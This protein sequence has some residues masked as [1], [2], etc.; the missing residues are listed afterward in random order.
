[1][2]HGQRRHAF[3]RDTANIHDAPADKENQ[4]A[5][6]KLAAPGRLKSGRRPLGQLDNTL[7]GSVPRA[8]A[9]PDG[10]DKDVTSTAKL[11][12]LLNQSETTRTPGSATVKC[13]ATPSLT[14]A[15]AALVRRPAATA[16]HQSSAA[17]CWLE[18]TPALLSRTRE[19]ARR[20]QPRCCLHMHQ[21]SA[22]N[23]LLVASA[24]GLM[25]RTRHAHHASS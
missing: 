25:C 5:P 2:S 15:P 21:P 24:Y 1:M 6:G 9:K 22:A 10:T 18:T 19:H 12:T 11:S 4:D 23:V 3:L 8:A 17:V 16:L 20:M 14:S 7:S 13:S